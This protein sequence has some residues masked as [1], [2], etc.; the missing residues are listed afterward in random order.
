MGCESVRKRYWHISI[1]VVFADADDGEYRADEVV[2]GRFGFSLIRSGNSEEFRFIRVTVDECTSCG[3]IG[4]SARLVDATELL[5][6][7]LVAS[8]DRAR[9]YRSQ[10]A[11]K[12]QEHVPV[13][14]LRE[15]S[16]LDDAVNEVGL[17]FVFQLNQTW[18]QGHDGRIAP[19]IS[20]SH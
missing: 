20:G 17:N 16:K 18:T 5:K 6:R 9:K 4:P 13:Y 19:S 8:V 7:E 3:V 12:N 15:L 1:L 11:F 14:I 2:R 10:E